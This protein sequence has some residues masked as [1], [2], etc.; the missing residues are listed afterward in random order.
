MFS[1]T[2]L[3]LFYLNYFSASKWLFPHFKRYQIYIYIKIILNA[4][5]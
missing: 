1:L 4:V 5:V 3:I 2:Y